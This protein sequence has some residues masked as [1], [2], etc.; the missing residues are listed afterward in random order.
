MTDVEKRYELDDDLSNAL[1]DT[2]QQLNDILHDHNSSSI[3]LEISLN[4]DCNPVITTEVTKQ[5]QANVTIDETG[6]NSGVISKGRKYAPV[7]WAGIVKPGGIKH[8][9]PVNTLPDVP[10][11]IQADLAVKMDLKP[12]ESAIN[13]AIR[14]LKYYN[15]AGAP[16][17]GYAEGALKELEMAGFK[18]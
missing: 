9:E 7:N 10:P 15:E 4:R 1:V 12:K 3:K 18:V 16:G 11:Q 6:M 5:P 17:Y 2:V 14:A 8:S 13:I